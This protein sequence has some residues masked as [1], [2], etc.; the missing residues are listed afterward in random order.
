MDIKLK[1][2][3]MLANNIIRKSF[4]SGKGSFYILKRHKYLI[5]YKELQ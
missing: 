5:L 3:C 2:K 1:L 4:K